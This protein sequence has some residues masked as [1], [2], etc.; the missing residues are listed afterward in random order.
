MPAGDEYVYLLTDENEILQEV[1]SADQY[2]FEGSSNATQRVYG[3]HFDGQ[4]NP[5][6]GQNRINTT[7]DGC[8]EH[9]SGTEFIE[10]IKDACF[11]CNIS[12]VSNANGNNSLDICPTD[13][14][15]DIVQLQNSLGL[16]AGNNYVYLLTDENET[17]IEVINNDQYNF[18]GSNL[19]LSLIHI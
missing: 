15:N 12:T 14:D 19:E 8:F 3:M 4:I 2:D 9:S 11:A 6:I 7:A 17:L 13:N 18:E 5:A 10:I 16:S 1:I